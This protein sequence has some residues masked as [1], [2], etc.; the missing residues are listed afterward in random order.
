MFWPISKNTI[1][2]FACYESELLPQTSNGAGQKRAVQT[3]GKFCFPTGFSASFPDILFP[4]SDSSLRYDWV[5]TSVC[6]S[7]YPVLPLMRMHRE[8][9]W[10][11]LKA[12]VSVWAGE[13]WRVSAITPGTRGREAGCLFGEIRG[14]RVCCPIHNTLHPHWGLSL[15]HCQILIRWVPKSQTTESV[16]YWCSS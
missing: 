12:A 2:L 6:V 4:H 14:V 1:R 15:L 13:Q 10:A 9:G 5:V 11:V 8:A 3:W 16:L 7:V